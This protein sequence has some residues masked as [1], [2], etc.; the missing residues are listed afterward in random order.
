MRFLSLKNAPVG[1]PLG[2]VASHTMVTAASSTDW[3]ASGPPRSVLVQP[4]HTEFTITFFPSAASATISEGVK[5]SSLRLTLVCKMGAG[6]SRSVNPHPQLH[7][8]SG[9]GKFQMPP[10]Q[11]REGGHFPIYPDPIKSIAEP[12]AD[13]R[14]P[15]RKHTMLSHLSNILFGRS[16]QVKRLEYCGNPD[17][18]APK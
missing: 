2:C 15:E 9:C 10:P 1:P 5:G 3:G 16:D 17:R 14:Y 13:R 8:E 11:Q 6:T 4:G 12:E 7:D 18:S